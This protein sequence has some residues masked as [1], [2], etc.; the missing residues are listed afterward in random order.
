M[1][2]WGEIKSGSQSQMLEGIPKDGTNI[3]TGG[4][5]RIVK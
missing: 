5:V 1:R 4:E 3:V 2:Q